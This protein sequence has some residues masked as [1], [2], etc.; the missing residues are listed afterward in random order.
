[1][2]LDGLTVVVLT[3]NEAPNIGRTL[4]RLRWASRVILID[5]GSDDGTTTIAGR[6]H[7]TQVI[8]RSFDCF[9]EQW[10]FGLDQVNTAWTLTLD[11]DYVL[12]AD[13]V[14]ALA[15][16]M[17]NPG[18]VY[19]AQFNYLIDGQKI[20]GSILPP[21]VVLFE[22]GSLR[23]VQ[24]GHT[25]LLD[26]KGVAETLPFMIAHDDRKPLKRWLT[27]Q[28]RYAF[29]EAE[30]LMAGLWSDLRWPDR[31]RRMH[32]IAPLVVPLI[33]LIRGAAFSGRRGWYYAAQR[34][35][36][37]LLLSLVLLSKRIEKP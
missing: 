20:R 8:T 19:Q 10:N 27:S 36:A 25:Q 16:A 30:K 29:E 6:F 4:E 22:T 11:A 13:C 3:F 26:F 31:L 15:Q 17:A 12:P 35:Y 1:M 32:V 24:D 33:A 37:E 18:S 9:R 34:G 14:D 21:R 7:N 5:S 28:Q 2:T 23:Y